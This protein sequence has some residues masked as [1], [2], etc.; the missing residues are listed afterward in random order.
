MTRVVIKA[1][2]VGE[3]L[4]LR[5]PLKV[6]EQEDIRDG[7]LVDIEMSKAKKSWFGRT[8]GIGPMTREDELDT[9]D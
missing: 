2:R 6:V 5:L 1:E 4:T 7:D 3:S 8:P 9:H